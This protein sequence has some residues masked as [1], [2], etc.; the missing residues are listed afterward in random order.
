MV[1]H[2][3]TGGDA[4]KARAIKNSTIEERAPG[5]PRGLKQAGK[6]AACADGRRQQS[7]RDDTRAPLKDVICR[8]RRGHPTSRELADRKHSIKTF[9]KPLASQQAKAETG[10]PELLA[11][12]RHQL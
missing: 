6:C 7:A 10:I 8:N 5:I 9:T 2:P 1:Q 11:A 12:Q 3:R 4:G